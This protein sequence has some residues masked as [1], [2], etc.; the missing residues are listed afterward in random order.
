[1]SNEISPQ[2][3]QGNTAFPHL[4]G[5]VSPESSLNPA[6]FPSFQKISLR[7]IST[8]GWEELYEI[9]PSFRVCR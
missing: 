3:I 8:S 9:E 6:E 2:R 1:M 5:I 7:L 4:N